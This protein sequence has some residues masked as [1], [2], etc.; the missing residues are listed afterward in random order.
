MGFKQRNR[1]IRVPC[2]IIEGRDREAETGS[3]SARDAPNSFISEV[4]KRE[5]YELFMSVAPVHEDGRGCS[6][7]GPSPL[8][9]QVVARKRVLT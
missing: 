4:R 3:P 7:S 8:W 5:E 9:P 6:Q 1:W 2:D